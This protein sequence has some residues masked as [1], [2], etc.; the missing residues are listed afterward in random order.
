MFNIDA[1]KK[2]SILILLNPI[3]DLFTGV[4]QYNFESSISFGG[5]FRIIILVY[6]VIDLLIQFYVKERTKL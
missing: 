6:L 3:I 2:I 4:S 5:I 1:K